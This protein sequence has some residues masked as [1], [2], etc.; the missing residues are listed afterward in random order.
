[1]SIFLNIKPKHL[2]EFIHSARHRVIYVAPG[3]DIEIASALINTTRKLGGDNVLIA[4]DV[5]ENVLRFGYGDISGI[6]LLKEQSV[7]IKDI[8]GLRIGI[9]IHDNEGLVF[10]PTP[11]VIETNKTG[12]ARFNA[13]STTPEQVK[14]I[15]AISELKKLLSDPGNSESEIESKKELEEKIEKIER[16]IKENPP[17]QF[18]VE[19][20]VRVFST[21]IE[22]VEIRLKKCDIQRHTVSIPSNLLVGNVDKEIERRLRTTFGIVGGKSNLSSKSL[23]EKVNKLKGLYMKYIPEY[24]YVLL[25][26][27]KD[28]FLREL[29]NVRKKVENFQKKVES[30]L[31][32][33]ITE[34]KKTLTEILTPAVKENPPVDLLSG[35]MGDKPTEEQVKKYLEIQLNQHLPRAENVVKNM[36]LD[37]IFKGVTHE[38]ISN[39]KFQKNIRK[40]YPLINWD[41]MMKEYD[42]APSTFA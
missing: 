36:S 5:S 14:D 8:G 33:E 6:T 20:N 26:S 2:I 19:R 15:L 11:L 37:C 17:Q 9:L 40:A 21:L 16:A 32:D 3:V 42:A 39:Q 41:E 23:H 28:E 29:D 34:T 4:L 22:F 12:R 7:S 35:I 24:G 13:V 31:D 38:T 10:T 25:K 18:D 1:M 30:K 27:K